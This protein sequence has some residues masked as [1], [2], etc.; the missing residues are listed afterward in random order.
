MASFGV[1]K[2]E[3]LP[4][5][6]PALASPFAGVKQTQGKI[7]GPLVLSDVQGAVGLASAGNGSVANRSNTPSLPFLRIAL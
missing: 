5:R 3:P 4:S 2:T 1:C 6:T 7:R